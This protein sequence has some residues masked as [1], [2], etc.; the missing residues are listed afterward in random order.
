MDLDGRVLAGCLRSGSYTLSFLLKGE[1]GRGPRHALRLS[2]A[3][4]GGRQK[5]NNSIFIAERHFYCRQRKMENVQERKTGSGRKR[6]RGSGCG[7][8][9]RAMAME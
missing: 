1:R 6:K 7:R 2:A 9:R 8:G 5:G 3:A 4:T